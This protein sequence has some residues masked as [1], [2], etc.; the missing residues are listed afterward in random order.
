VV[1]RGDAQQN[2][3]PRPPAE[4][5]GEGDAEGN[6]HRSRSPAVSSGS[7]KPWSRCAAADAK[8]H[9]PHENV[10]NRQLRHHVKR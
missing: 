5:A 4:E 8:Q 7:R 2:S 3:R 9:K 6:V 10:V 1:G